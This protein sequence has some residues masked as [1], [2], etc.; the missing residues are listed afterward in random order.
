MSLDNVLPMSLDNSVTYV[1][2]RFK[3]NILAFPGSPRASTGWGLLNGQ[4]GDN[5]PICAIDSV[6][7]SEN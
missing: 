1:L 5:L 7:A 4:T 6:P 2:E 3:W